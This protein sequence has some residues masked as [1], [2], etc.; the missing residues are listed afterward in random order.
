L[1]GT[2]GASGS[3][4]VFWQFFTDFHGLFFKGQSWLFPD[5]DTLIRLYPLKFWEDAVLYNGVIAALGAFACV[6]VPRDIR[7]TAR[8]DDRSRT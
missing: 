7:P 8:P 4:D 1:V 3:G 2:V 6:F 5:S